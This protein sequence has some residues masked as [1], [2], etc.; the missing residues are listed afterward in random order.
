MTLTKPEPELITLDSDDDVTDQ[1]Q[2][3]PVRAS[4]ACDR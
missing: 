1:A 4:E 2:V 3:G